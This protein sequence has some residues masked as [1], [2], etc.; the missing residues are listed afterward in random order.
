MKVR[1]VNSPADIISP[2]TQQALQ[3]GLYATRNHLPLISRILLSAL[4]LWSAVNKILH[5]GMTQQYM[6][7][8]GMPFTG[9]LLAGAIALELL[10]GLSLLLGVQAR[11]GASI[12]AVFTLIAT[13]IF[14]TNFTDQIQQIMFMKNLSIIGGLLMVVQHGPGNIALRPT[15]P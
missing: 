3:T 9:V 7:A 14:H 8:Y 2:K 10:G 13:F 4:F 5:P 11:W 15:K 12:L 1:I 6:A